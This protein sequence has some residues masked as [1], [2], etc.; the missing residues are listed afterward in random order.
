MYDG[1]LLVESE[2]S[3]NFRRDFIGWLRKKFKQVLRRAIFG[4]EK[5][6]WDLNN[7]CNEHKKLLFKIN[8]NYHH[9]AIDCAMCPTF[10][11][12]NR[13]QNRPLSRE[14]TKSDVNFPN[15]PGSKLFPAEREIETNMHPPVRSHFALFVL[16][17]AGPAGWSTCA[18]VS[19]SG[20][21]DPGRDSKSACERTLSLSDL[22]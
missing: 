12:S 7:D 21:I 4:G 13:G 10:S 18:P 14:A 5:P 2:Q 11:A 19:R 17:F 22:S 15:A 16:F 3:L 6:H 20:L 1:K 9:E 8:S